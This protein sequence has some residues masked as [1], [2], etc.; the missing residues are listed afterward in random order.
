MTQIRIRADYEPIG[1]VIADVPLDEVDQVV[2]RLLRE[3]LAI[4]GED[5]AR[6]QIVGGFIVDTVTREAYFEIFVES[7]DE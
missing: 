3:G 2:N 4:D 7:S 5:V 6:D 1:A